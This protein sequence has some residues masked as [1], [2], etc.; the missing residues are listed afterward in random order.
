ML[1]V[2]DGG[3][4]RILIRRSRLGLSLY[5]VGSHQLAAFRSGVPIGRTKLVA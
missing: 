4:L 1:I 5:A 3:R 2:I